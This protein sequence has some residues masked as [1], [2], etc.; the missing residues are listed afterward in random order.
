MTARHPDLEDL[1]VLVLVAKSG[2]IG[3]AAAELGLSQ[4]TVSRRMAALERSLRVPLL[5]R[6]RRGSTLTPEGRVV[7]DW[8]STLLDAADVFTRSVR[9]LREE[10]AVTVRVGVSMTIAEH[11]AP[12]W[13]ARL[14]A[15][16]PESVVSLVVTNS[17]EVADLVESA[18]VDIGF[19]E[20]PTVRANLHRRRVGW[21]RLVVAV[22]PGHPWATRR[23]PVLANDLAETELLMREAG[24]GTRETLEYALGRHG[25][26]PSPGFVMASN[27]ALKSAAVAGMGPIVLSERALAGEIASGQLLQVRVAELE[28]SRPLTAVWRRNEPLPAAATGLIQV[29]LDSRQAAP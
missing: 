22:P 28:L 7:V 17:K 1:A 24:S 16:S 18:R 29:A 11:H 27:T 26:K 9:T 2:S 3:Q 21:D 13:I 14:H 15:R 4:P 12:G 20:S 23:R 10:T 5:Q 25:L 19:L 8:A 6:S